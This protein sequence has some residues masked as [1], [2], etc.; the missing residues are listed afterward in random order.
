MNAKG[1][2]SQCSGAIQFDSSDMGQA[3]ECPI[4]GQ[5]TTLL[6]PKI[7]AKQEDERRKKIDLDREAAR[8]RQIELAAEREREKTARLYKLRKFGHYNRA[9]SLLN[10]YA[11]LSIVTVVL[12]ILVYFA[13][14]IRM[15]GFPNDAAFSIS[16]GNAF[17]AFLI[18]YIG[19]AIFDIADCAVSKHDASKIQ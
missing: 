5:T 12:F 13:S 10:A 16:I 14:I 7:E 6:D 19:N 4:C 9:R 2:C 1:N 8:L 18:K 17:V 3:V 11:V 15:N